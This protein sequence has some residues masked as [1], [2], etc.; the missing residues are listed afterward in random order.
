MTVTSWRWPLNLALLP[1]WLIQSARVIL[2]R[3]IHHCFN[4]TSEIWN[5]KLKREIGNR[6]T[7]TKLS[8]LLNIGWEFGMSQRKEKER[9]REKTRQRCNQCSPSSCTFHASLYL[10]HFHQRLK[11]LLFRD[12][13]ELL[14]LSLHFMKSYYCYEF[15]CSFFCFLLKSYCC[16][17]IVMNPSNFGF[18]LSSSDEWAIVD[19]NM[20][21][22]KSW[23]WEQVRG[24]HKEILFTVNWK[25]INPKN[26]R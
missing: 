3:H 6:K 18:Y 13:D 12:W 2:P 14:F 25:K 10:L 9:N 23:V 11:E 24:V 21:S 22:P 5:S 16:S 20:G 4:I 26:W 15:Y 17:E 1:P 7:K 8:L 19:W